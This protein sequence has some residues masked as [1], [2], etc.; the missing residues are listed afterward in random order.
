MAKNHSFFE[1]SRVY[2]PN[3][4]ACNAKLAYSS[5]GGLPNYY[6]SI[7]EFQGALNYNKL[8]S[9]LRDAID[10]RSFKHAI[11]NLSLNP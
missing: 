9:F 5:A 4:N 6:R 2:L 3:K 11:C 7:F 8:P 10:H 1:Y